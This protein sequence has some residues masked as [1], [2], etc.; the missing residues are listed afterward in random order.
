MTDL[1][2][3]PD[4][5]RCVV[6]REDGGA[7]TEVWRAGIYPTPFIPSEEL[8]ALHRIKAHEGG[9]VSDAD[10]S[11]RFYR[12]REDRLALAYTASLPELR[13]YAVAMRGDAVFIAGVGRGKRGEREALF[14]SDGALGP[15][16]KFRPV[17]IPDSLRWHD[18]KGIDALVFDGDTL[19]AVD[20]VYAPLYFLIYDV[21]DPHAPRLVRTVEF[22]YPGSGEE[23]IAATMGTCLA[24]LTCFYDRTRV[25]LYERDTFTEYG[26]LDLG[27]FEEPESMWRSMVFSGDHLYVAAGPAG[28]GRV[29]VSEALSEHRRKRDRWRTWGQ[30]AGLCYP[31]LD[32]TPAPSGGSV[33]FITKGRGGLY[34]HTPGRGGARSEWLPIEGG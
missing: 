10:Q 30:E 34:L 9:W 1:L 13:P 5:D 31:E 20:N 4:D 3:L 6:A 24:V 32:Y 28:V 29:N 22:Q 8:R 11:V 27:K 23:V 25:H 21:R 26:Y 15:D 12:L 33:C 17:E 18:R 16:T 14:V 19:I 2:V 7:L